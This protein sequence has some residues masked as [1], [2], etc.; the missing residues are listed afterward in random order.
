[1][2]SSWK[3]KLNPDQANNP[4]SQ[5]HQNKSKT[6]SSTSL[7]KFNPTE[8]HHSYLIEITERMRDWQAVTASITTVQTE[9]VMRNTTCSWLQQFLSPQFGSI[10]N[11]LYTLHTTKHS[12]SKFWVS[13]N[14]FEFKTWSS[15]QK[16]FELLEGQNQQERTFNFVISHIKN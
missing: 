12:Q 11:P 14:E 8:K 9:T 16:R 1:M 2:K 13:S 15:V 4:T 6:H 3:T 7:P 5:T 10:R